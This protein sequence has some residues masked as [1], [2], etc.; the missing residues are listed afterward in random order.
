MKTKFLC[1]PEEDDT[2]S[3]CGWIRTLKLEC[4]FDP[5]DDRL[6]L[7]GIVGEVGSGSVSDTVFLWYVSL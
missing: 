5:A 1:D 7:S 3:V 2:T 4:V 6:E